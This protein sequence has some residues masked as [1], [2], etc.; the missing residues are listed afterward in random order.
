MSLFL[1]QALPSAEPRGKTCC[2]LSRRP[3]REGR[4]RACGVPSA[5]PR[6]R[7]ARLPVSEMDTASR[8]ILQ[9]SNPLFFWCRLSRRPSLEGGPRACR[10]QRSMIPSERLFDLP[11]EFFN[12]CV[13]TSF[14][15]N[16]HF[17]WRLCLACRECIQRFVE[18]ATK[19]L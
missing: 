10:L 9:C 8:C 11:F 12:T 5:E 2:R 19:T 15:R 4:P 6:R 17:K 7:A 13:T 1:L 16:L 3:S 18:L 14:R